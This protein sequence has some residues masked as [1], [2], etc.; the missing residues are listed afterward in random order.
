M[1]R[2][3]SI[4]WSLVV[5]SLG[6]LAPLVGF[7]LTDVFIKFSKNNENPIVYLSE[8]VNLSAG[9]AGLA[10]IVRPS[11]IS[12]IFVGDIML[13][14]GVENSVLKNGQGDFSFL[15][16]K[17]DFVKQADIAFGNLEGPI[18]S[19]G[20]DVGSVYSFRF[21]PDALGGLIAAGFDVLSVANNHAG[22]WGANAFEEN[23]FRLNKNY[24][25]SVGGGFNKRDAQQ[26][27]ILKWK[28]VKFGFLGFSDVGPNWFEAKE[29]EPGILMIKDSQAG[30][31]SSLIKKA[32]S[33]VDVLIVSIHFGEEYQTSAN[34]RQRHLAKLA[35]DSGAKIV[36]GHHPH[37]IQEVE[38]YKGGII[39][40]SLG[41][42]IFDQNF[43]EET[44]E[45]L[46]LQIYFEGKEI[47]AV[48]KNKI[49]INNFF[50]PALQELWRGRP[51]LV[52]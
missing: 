17:T 52:E 19:V 44:M 22:D 21:R 46:A 6:F 50:Q 23:I 48:K 27:K 31:F 9:Q 29:D 51:E 7:C 2:I 3:K 32:A 34:D 35:I 40:Y 13:G 47:I 18:A 38:Q 10:S 8:R 12:M 36:A 33:E 1:E 39:A 49:K 28:G 24:V 45:G 41:N 14:R 16:E 20:E 11:N 26:V 42:F 15:F 25:Y 30:E 37:V 4:I 5:L 43:S